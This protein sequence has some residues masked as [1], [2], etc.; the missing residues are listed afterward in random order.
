[1]SGIEILIDAQICFSAFYYDSLVYLIITEPIPCGF[2]YNI[3]AMSLICVMT[4][5]LLLSSLSE[6]SCPFLG[7]TPLHKIESK[8]TCKLVMLFKMRTALHL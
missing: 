1:M 8:F 7:F 3:F 4:F 5:S 6:L 2:N